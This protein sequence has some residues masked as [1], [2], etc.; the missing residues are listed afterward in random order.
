[1][2]RAEERERERGYDMKTLGMTLIDVYSADRHERKKIKRQIRNEGR[3]GRN[4]GREG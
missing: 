3:G 1:V 4:K 2:H